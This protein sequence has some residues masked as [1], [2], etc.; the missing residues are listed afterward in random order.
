[1][2]GEID[3]NH[4]AIRWYHFFFGPLLWRREAPPVNDELIGHHV[5]DYRQYD[6]DGVDAAPRKTE[7]QGM[8]SFKL[9]NQTWLTLYQS[10]PK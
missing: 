10:R 2:S 4:S 1:M 7:H 6:R 5:P 9:F 8:L 3:T